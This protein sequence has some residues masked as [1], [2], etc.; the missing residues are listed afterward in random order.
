MSPS[1]RQMTR[2]EATKQVS[3]ALATAFLAQSVKNA[4]TEPGMTDLIEG[5]EADAKDYLPN[6][7]LFSVE[8]PA[9]A[10]TQVPPRRSKREGIDFAVREAI[11]LLGG[12]AE[13]ARNKDR[14]LIKPNLV[15]PTVSDTTAP[16]VVE[17]L[18][19]LMTEAGKDV[20]IGE[21]AAAS[22]PNIRRLWKGFVC[23]TKDAETLNGIQDEVFDEL[24]FRDLSER[25]KVRLVNLHVGDMVRYTI[26]DNSVFKDIF[27]HSALHEADLV[28]SVPMM[29]THGLA[30]V[31]LGMKNFIG[32][33]PG[34]VYGTVRSRVHQVA[35]RVSRRR[36]R[37]GDEGRPDG[38][39]RF[40]GD[41]GTGTVHR[42]GGRAGRD[43]PDR[44][45]HER[46]GHGHGR[47]VRDGLRA[48]GDLHVRMG[49]EGGDE[50]LPA[51]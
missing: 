6:P 5:I 43:G 47:G 22:S 27:L 51:R 26:P 23:R 29:K 50:A 9:V 38:H 8:K 15:S 45:G 13:V 36:H 12:M 17:A 4:E 35:S 2:R 16:E 20:S 40:D 18:V 49:L 14:V 3:G 48:G 34:Q 31:T 30:G 33:Y 1:R 42:N 39:R 11:D 37:Q 10:I 7:L 21:G 24:G 46:P 28:C 25:M 41:A 32:A 19:R 44:R